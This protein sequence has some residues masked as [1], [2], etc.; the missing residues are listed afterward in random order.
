[1]PKVH[2]DG[3]AR[4]C[5][6]VTVVEGQSSV[7]VNGK[8]WAVEG[9]P[10]SHNEGRLIASGSSVYINGK[11]VIVHA[12]DDATAD[13]AGHPPATTKTAEGSGSVYTYG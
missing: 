4:V 2:R 8:L 5:G 6:A 11:K 9:D 13:L 3:D 7:Y 12:P 1:M 10:N